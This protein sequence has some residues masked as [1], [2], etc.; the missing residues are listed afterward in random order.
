MR[1]ALKL[2][3]GT[4]AWV[5]IA[6]ALLG[7][8]GGAF[9]ALDA[10]AHFRLHFLLFI[11]VVALIAVVARQWNVLWRLTVASLFLLAGLGPLWE[12]PERFGVGKPLRI[13]TA[14]I[15]QFN[16]QPEEMRA[17][18]LEANPDVLVTNETQK[19][20]GRGSGSLAERY[21]YRL[22]L[23]TTGDVLR[24]VI[25]SK[26]PMREGQLLLDDLVEPTGAHA[27]IDLGQGFEVTVLALHLAHPIIG[28]QQIQIEALDRLAE[29]LPTPRIVLGDFNATPWSWAVMRIEDLTGTK[30]IGG[31][32]PTWFGIYPNEFGRLRALLGQPIDHVLTSETVGVVSIETVTIP[33]SDHKGIMADLLVPA[34]DGFSDGQ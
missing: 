32:R 1:W 2:L 21:P 19:S 17:V 22:S 34:A 16:R 28:N 13:M 25:W 20:L 26:Y 3:A 27:T 12:T 30:R 29:G 31:Y 9:F 10:L 15:Y 6:C 5:I 18:F 7:Y 4:A 23:S 8:G 11:P 33:G 14:N 24:T